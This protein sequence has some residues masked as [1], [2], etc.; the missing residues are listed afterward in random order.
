MVSAAPR[1][2]LIVSLDN[3]GDLALACALV[4]AL[5]AAFPQAE[6]GVW[7]K[8]YAAGLL[9]FVPGVTLAHASDPF[10]DKSPG[11]GS[12]SVLGFLR[13]L[14]EV[15][16]GGYDAALLPNTRWRTAFAARAAGIPRRVGFDQRGGG[17]WLSDA[18]SAERRD[19]PV[20]A[21]WARLLTPLGA[22]AARAELR[23][24]V[25][26]FL[27]EARESL[28]ARL[29]PGSVAAVHPFAGDARRCAP[30]A[31]WIEFLR[32]LKADGVAKAVVIGAAGE[33]RAF[34]AEIASAS[35]LPE[36][37]VA[38]ELGRGTLAES[39]LAISLCDVFI[40]HDSGPLHCAAGLGIPALGLYLPGDW[41]RAMPQGRAAW[42]AVRR[43]SP[44][45]AD[46][47][48]AASLARELLV[49]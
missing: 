49:R 1:R 40:G 48:E 37:A 2:I 12:G 13:A 24:E 26:A 3:L 6:I 14:T 31:F 25:P 43:S 18:L 45:E 33:S 17:R 8:E 47:A 22:E 46:P 44:A 28:R 35:G 42:K 21:E 4:P 41:P 5:R 9:P 38:A 19:Q 32:R 15:R 36:L 7:A 27:D 29:T 39:L 23:L 10:W 34:A 16:F 11:R 20:V 30:T